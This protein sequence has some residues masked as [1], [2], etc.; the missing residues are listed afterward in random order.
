MAEDLRG[1]IGEAT[2]QAQRLES[3]IL[4]NHGLWLESGDWLDLSAVREVRTIVACLDDFGPL[5]IATDALVRANLLAGPSIP[6]IV[7]LHDLAVIAK[8]LTMPASFLLY[9][10]RRTEPEASR[11]FMAVDELD[12]LMWF[13]QGGFYFEPDPDALHQRYPMAPPPTNRD[14]ARYKNE[15][16]TQVGTLTDDLDAWM[17]YEEDKSDAAAPKPAWA[18]NPDIARLVAFL[19]EDHKPGWLRFGADLLN[20]SGPAQKS[21]VR[22]MKDVAKMTRRDHKFHSMAQ[23]YVNPWGYSVLFVGGQPRRSEPVLEHLR[24][25]MTAKK[26]QLRA[27]RALWIL[28]SETTEVL[29]VGYDN[30]PYEPDEELDS[31]VA[32]MGLVPPERMTRSVVPPTRKPRPKRSKAKSRRK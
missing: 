31:I 22:S 14:R 27:D 9:L 20:L 6:W 10:R 12:L 11:L 28:L 29:A 15:V 17:Y 32:S 24:L 23:G 3:L 26:R 19:Q 4:G 1:T 2:A 30:D 13:L 5:A 25:Y 8:V 7:S 16:P 21:L 18:G